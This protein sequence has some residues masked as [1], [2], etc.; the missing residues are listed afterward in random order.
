[1]R[2]KMRRNKRSNKLQETASENKDSSKIQKTKHACIVEAHES[3]RNFLESILPR[4]HEDHI[5]GQVTT[6]WRTSPF[7]CFKR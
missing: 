6:I 1:M 2:C 7:R 3:T 5:E 4:D